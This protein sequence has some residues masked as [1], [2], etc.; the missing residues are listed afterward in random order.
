MVASQETLDKL[1]DIGLNMYERKIYAALLGRGVS[2]AGELSEMTNVP[3]SRAYDVL[4]SLAEKGFV[5][6]KS[7]KPMEYVSIPPNEAI[8]NIKKQHKQELQDKLNKLEGFKSSEAVQELEELYDQGVELVEPS[9]MS[10]SLKGSHQINQHMGT[11][12]QKAE[13]AIKIATTE[14]GLNDLVENHA[15]LLKEAKADGVNVQILAPVTDSNRSSFS[16]AKEFAE[17]RHLQETG[18]FKI[19][20]GRFAIVD[21]DMTMSMTHDEVHSTQDT[22]FWTRSDHMSKETM[23]PVFDM[24]WHHSEDPENNKPERPE[25]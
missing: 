17:V 8:E 14:E 6:I 1:E 15:D 25:K 10:G 2:T 11:M 13:S 16:N 23:E 12:F 18:E 24:L 3:R 20:N 21:D 19:P 7:S 9:E 4:E 22:A 5:V